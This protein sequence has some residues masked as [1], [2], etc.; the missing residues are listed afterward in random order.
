MSKKWSR[1]DTDK[2]FSL[3]SKYELRWPVIFDRFSVS[4]DDAVARKS[5][6][7]ARTLPDLKQRFYDCSKA[8][9]LNQ[10]K[11]HEASQYVYDFDADKTR[12]E[13]LDRSYRRTKAEEAE[14]KRLKEELKSINSELHRLERCVKEK[15]K[16]KKKFLLGTTENVEATSSFAAGPTLWLPSMFVKSRNYLRSARMSARQNASGPGNRQLKKMDMIISELG[17]SGDLMATDVICKTYSKLRKSVLK[18]L[19]L[20]KHLSSLEARMNS[21]TAS[22]PSVEPARKRARKGQ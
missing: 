4:Y 6:S 2:L 13:Q 14:E 12:S 7:N 8:L 20:Q 1:D 10:K 21:T 17:V 9:L 18:V 11:I 22:V 15:S 3:A 19:S 16:N 5:V